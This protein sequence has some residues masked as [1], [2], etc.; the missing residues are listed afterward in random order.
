MLNGRKSP[1]ISIMRPQKQLK[2]LIYCAFPMFSTKPEGLDLTRGS[3]LLVHLSSI[4][5]SLSRIGCRLPK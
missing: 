2:C 3:Q 4:G 1:K 5:N